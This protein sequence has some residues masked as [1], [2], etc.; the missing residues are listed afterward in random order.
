MLQN[1]DRKAIFMHIQLNEWIAVY[2]GTWYLMVIISLILLVPLMLYNNIFLRPKVK[3][4]IMSHRSLCEIYCFSQCPCF[5]SNNYVL[6]T[7]RKF[8]WR[9]NRT[10]VGPS[11]CLRVCVSVRP[12]KYSPYKSGHFYISGVV[13]YMVRKRII[14][15]IDLWLY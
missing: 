5:L 7:I 14:N 13:I 3:N 15:A 2:H 12:L 4:W 1:N 9:L 6:Y 8:F 11:V 10:F